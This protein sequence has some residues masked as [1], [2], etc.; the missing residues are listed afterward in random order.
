MSAE[1]V[2]TI[3]TESHLR[4]ARALAQAAKRYRDVDFVALVIDAKSAPEIEGAKTLLPSDLA[5]EPVRGTQ[6]QIR[7]T[8][9]SILLQHLLE[10]Y[11]R[12]I[13][14]DPDVLICNDYGFLFEQLHETG[15]LLTP[16]WRPINTPSDSQYPYIFTDG[17]FQAGFIGAS[18]DGLP[19]LRWWEAACRRS[20]VKHNRRGLW[21]DQKYLDVFPAYF[22]EITTVVT[23][24]GCNVAHWNDIENRRERVGDE[25]LI[26]GVDPIIF[27][28]V[29][30][31]RDPDL[32]HLYEAYDRAL[33]E[34]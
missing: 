24:R 29:S 11:E 14:F 12:A 30:G 16:H 5:S 13:F 20:C 6:D 17:M 33:A 1:V 34:S 3:V 2:C 27:V 15:I 8:S 19:A 21:V 31:M 9:K 26:N 25:V 7:W 4:Y 10:T 18:R 22:S 28:H 23:H 32:A